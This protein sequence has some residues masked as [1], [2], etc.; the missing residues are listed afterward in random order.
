[1]G[2]LLETETLEYWVDRAVG[3]TVGRAAGGRAGGRAAV[4]RAGRV[5]NTPLVNA[6]L[7]RGLLNIGCCL[8]DGFCGALGALLET[9]AVEQWVLSWGRGLS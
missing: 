5:F 9:E 3:R 7:Q 8:G 1:M 6:F 2:A 4:G